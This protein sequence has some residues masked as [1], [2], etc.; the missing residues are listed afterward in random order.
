MAE[1]DSLNGM[2]LLRNVLIA[3]AVIL[4]ILFIF[5]LFFS[6]HVIINASEEIHAPAKVVFANINNLHNQKLWYPFKNDSVTPD[7]IPEPGEGVGA[8]R[9]WIKGDTILRRLVIRKSEPER[10]VKA[11]L[12]FGKKKGAIQEWTL[13]GDSIATHVSWRFQVLNLH[14]PL[15]KWLG[16]IMRNSMKPALK[17]GLKRLKKVSEAEVKSAGSK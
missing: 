14:Y 7:S 12:L 4:G 1:K 15:G 16:L 13:T 10:Y 9:I 3:L 11:L 8:Q 17:A 2:G 6:N 5:P